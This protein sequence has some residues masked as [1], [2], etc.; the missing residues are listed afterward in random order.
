V[1]GQCIHARRCLTHCVAQN[2][3]DT[4]RLVAPAHLCAEAYRWGV[5]PKSRMREG[6]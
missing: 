3:Q 1:C 5:F 2:Y 6:K 4:G